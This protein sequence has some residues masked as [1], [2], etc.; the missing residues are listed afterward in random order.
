MLHN[1]SRAGK[2]R[3]G[4]LNDK[5]AIHTKCWLLNVILG[6]FAEVEIIDNEVRI[7]EII[8]NY[9]FQS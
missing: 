5:W 9:L 3:Q 4:V 8:Y 7:Y 2:T 1:R 6:E